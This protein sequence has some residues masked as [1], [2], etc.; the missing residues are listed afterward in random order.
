MVTPAKQTGQ[1][2]GQLDLWT[3]ASVLGLLGG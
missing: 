3:F 2:G 1:L